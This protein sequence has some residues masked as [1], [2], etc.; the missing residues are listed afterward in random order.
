MLDEFL[1]STIVAAR[2]AGS[3]AAGD[4]VHHAAARRR[5]VPARRRA[6]RRA[7]AQYALFLASW[8]DRQGG[9][10]G[11]PGPGWLWGWALILLCT[12]PLV[13]LSTWC[14]ASSRSASA[15]CCAAPA[16]RGARVA[17]GHAQRDGVGRL[18]G[19]NDRAESLEQLALG[20]GFLSVLA[21]LEL[22]FVMPVLAAGAGGFAHAALL[23]VWLAVSAVLGLRLAGARRR[24]TDE[25][26]ALTGLTVEHIVGHRTRL[27]QELPDR[28]HDSE[29]EAL[30]RYLDRSVDLDRARSRCS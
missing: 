27:A 12:I 4:A 9:P 26:L 16:R 20:G 17:A 28:W 14:Q 22:A 10:A 21:L 30:A 11:P 19:R 29:D 1:A 25:R 13:M 5:A 7:R 2:L 24:W 3:L 6:A 23:V 18:L 15:C 8:C